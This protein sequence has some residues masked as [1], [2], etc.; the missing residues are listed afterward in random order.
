GVVK[1]GHF[2]LGKRTIDA[3]RVRFESGEAA[4]PSGTFRSARWNPDELENVIAYVGGELDAVSWLARARHLTNTLSRKASGKA[5]KV[6]TAGNEI[7]GI[8]EIKK[9]D[10]DKLIATDQEPESILP[11][12]SGLVEARIRPSTKIDPMAIAWSAPVVEE[13]VRL[14][15]LVPSTGSAAQLCSSLQG[16]FNAL[17]FPDRIGNAM[18]RAA[19]PEAFERCGLDLRGM[20]GVRRAMIAALEAS[21]IAGPRDDADSIRLGD[22]VE[23]ILRTI[24]S[25][26]LRTAAGAD[27]GVRVLEATELRGL[28]FQ[29]VFVAGLVEG[30]FPLRPQR[31]WIYPQEQRD[32]LKQYGLSLEDISSET[33]LKEE[34]YFYQVVCRA[35]ELLYLSRPLIAGDGGGS[36][37]TSRS[38]YIDELRRAVY[39]VE[40]KAEVL[41][42]DSSGA[43]PA[44][45]STIAELSVFLARAADGAETAEERLQ[46]GKLLSWAQENRFI[47]SSATER[48]A[49]ERE[50]DGLA[51]GEFDGRINDPALRKLLDRYFGPAHIF[52]ATRLSIYGKCPFRFFSSRVLGLEPRSEAALD[53]KVTDAGEL[54]HEIM[55]VFMAPKRGQGL[56]SA[57]AHALKLELMRTADVVFDQYERV[58]PPLNPHVWRI[59]REIRKLLLEQV[60]EY[61]LS[62][63][64]KTSESGIRP[65]LFELAFG[66]TDQGDDPSSKQQYLE[67]ERPGQTGGARETAKL[68][69]RIDRVDVAPDGTVL[70]YDYKLSKGATVGDMRAGRDVQLGAY[71]TALEAIFF[72]DGKLAGGGFYAFKGGSDRRNNGLYRQTFAAYTGINGQAA[73]SMKDHEWKSLREEI[74]QHIWDFM[75]GI[76]AGEF[77][78]MPSQG[79]K[80]CELCDFSAVCR[81]EGF[82]IRR[83]VASENPHE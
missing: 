80:T 29:V 13:I 82:R 81:Y 51:F 3:L 48:I 16:L 27:D 19:S 20:E 47:S 55:R 64:E 35:T 70:A 83:K 2:A 52:S 62:F 45:S 71:L 54:L 79:K 32:Q 56:D 40:I 50:R 8:A 31:D 78:V 77:V 68:R 6:P 26:V 46:A 59:D 76:R 44:D 73:S 33:L 21:R 72:P 43:D 9:A 34:H 69:G 66:M 4:G 65:A 30:G 28:K 5:A 39:P 42:R 12:E 75:H 41:H 14:I 74:S 24:R 36:A 67:I 15:D 7:F 1:S 22:L 61:E 49:V 25:Q 58:V 11:P 17:G 53:L 63:Q 57:D 23:E 10:I 37:P 60:L 18:K 38:Y